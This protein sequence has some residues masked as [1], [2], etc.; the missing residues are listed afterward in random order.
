MPRIALRAAPGRTSPDRPSGRPPGV[1]QPPRDRN[2]ASRH[3]G[4][5]QVTSVGGRAITHDGFVH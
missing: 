3:N 1:T 4:L 2:T 5:N